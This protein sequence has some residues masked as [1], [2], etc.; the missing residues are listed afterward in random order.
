VKISPPGISCSSPFHSYYHQ[1][2]TMR[3]FTDIDLDIH[4][5]YFIDTP[6]EF[7]KFALDEIEPNK[8][9]RGCTVAI[10]SH[11]ST[12]VKGGAGI[13]Q[14][15][16]GELLF[17]NSPGGSIGSVFAIKHRSLRG[18]GKWSVSPAGPET[19]F[20]LSII[21]FSE[22]SDPVVLVTSD[23][24]SGALGN[25][26]CEDGVLSGYAGGTL[27]R[28]VAISLKTHPTFQ[29]PHVPGLPGNEHDPGPFPARAE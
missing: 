6:R 25:Q 21:E 28:V 8:E 14:T 22:Q 5:I 19:S 29:L 4:P 16:T 2:N 9:F 11:D 13:T 7:V 20:S 1:E 10:S 27:N 18:K 12:Q 23:G 3:S 17:Y 26:R 15:G 24:K